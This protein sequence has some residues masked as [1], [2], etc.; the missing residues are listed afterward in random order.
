MINARRT[1]LG[2]KHEKTLKEKTPRP[3]VYRYKPKTES[4]PQAKKQL[5]IKIMKPK[6]EVAPIKE[7]QF[8]YDQKQLEKA[9]KAK[10][11]YAEI[12]SDKIKNGYKWVTR[13]GKYNI[14]ETVLIKI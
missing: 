6:K 5:P 13:K 3:Y 8:T 14:S 2:I 12:E 4:K 9:K 10:Q 7:S 1:E 11:D